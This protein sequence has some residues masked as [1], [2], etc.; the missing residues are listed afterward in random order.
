MRLFERHNGLSIHSSVLVSILKGETDQ[1]ITP[2]VSLNENVE[3]SSCKDT[4]LFT[5][6]ENCEKVLQRVSKQQKSNLNGF[7]YKSNASYDLDKG[8][9]AFILRCDYSIS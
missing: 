5:S 9:C 4:S 6:V 8:C 7:S 2:F 1:Q 3:C